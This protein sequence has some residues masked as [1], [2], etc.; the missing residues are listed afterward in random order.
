LSLFF[1]VFLAGA[2]AA[3]LAF[4]GADVLAFAGIAIAPRIVA[5]NYIISI[6]HEVF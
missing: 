3:V 5:C 4:A 2:L 6:V 1:A